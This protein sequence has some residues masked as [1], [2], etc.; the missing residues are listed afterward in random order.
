MRDSHSSLRALALV[1][2]L[3]VPC[4]QTSGEAARDAALTPAGQVFL[5][6]S[7]AC[8]DLL[9]TCAGGS[10]G[11]S[12]L[13]LEVVTPGE[14]S[15]TI[16]VPGTEG[17]E[18][19]GQPAIVF[20]DVSD[21]LFLIWESTV[22]SNSS[23]LNLVRYKDSQWSPIVEVSGDVHP[24]KGPP[25]V[26]L[27]RG[28]YHLGGTEETPLTRH[29]RSVLHVVW[30]EQGPGPEEVYYTPV[31][32]A[33]G[34]YLGRNLVHNL[35]ALDHSQPPEP[36][37]SLPPELHRAPAI[38][39]GRDEHSVVIGFT[40]PVSQHFVTFELRVVAGELSNLADLAQLEMI[41]QGNLY[42]DGQLTQFAERIRSHIIE[43]GQRLHS[44]ALA[45]L[46]D[47]ARAS[48]INQGPDHDGDVLFLSERIRSHI[49]EVGSRL[50]A[51]GGIVSDPLASTAT[52]VIPTRKQPEAGEEWGAG[53]DVCVQQI[54][55]RLAP[56]VGAGPVT[57]YLAPTG[58]RALASWQT[59]GGI[60]YRESVEN[61]WSETR[62]ITLD[63]AIDAIRAEQ[64]LRQRVREQ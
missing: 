24:L 48:I 10:E 28:E 5:A 11:N 42:Q 45:T 2:L 35:T 27:T 12:L 63:G 16:L 38:Q 43:V 39:P 55:S 59:A 13:T 44:F 23:S 61:G 62:R 33:D 60:Y 53:H 47:E 9:A 34:E 30:W 1:A 41:A 49:I 36:L 32:L 46:A 17:A 57:F 8:R 52:L 7:G 25:Q 20:E 15:R 26:V 54:D 6:R 58:R 18:A 3:G 29:V 19:E 40:N 64:I 56:E 51:S 50:H 31:I 21:S 4:F 37:L 14:P 22:P